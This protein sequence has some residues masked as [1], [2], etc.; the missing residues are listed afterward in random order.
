VTGHPFD[1]IA[2]DVWTAMDTPSRSSECLSDG[3]RRRHQIDAGR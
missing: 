1:A 2:E 3:L